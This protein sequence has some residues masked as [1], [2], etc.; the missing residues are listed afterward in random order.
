MVQKYFA[1]SECIK[2]CLQSLTG[3]EEA[4]YLQ[5]ASIIFADS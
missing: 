1:F 4:K 3:K 5:D 2:V